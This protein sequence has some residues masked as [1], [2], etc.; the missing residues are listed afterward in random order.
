MQH[1]ELQFDRFAELKG[2][3]IGDE[4]CLLADNICLALEDD[5]AVQGYLEPWEKPTKIRERNAASKSSIV[6]IGTAL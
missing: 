2:T 6:K 5:V 3:D 1:Y 4:S